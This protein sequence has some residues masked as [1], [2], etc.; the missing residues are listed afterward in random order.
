MKMKMKRKRR[1]Q[2]GDGKYSQEY[3]DEDV[4]KEE[5]MDHQEGG[6][7]LTKYVQGKVGQCQKSRRELNVL[8]PQETKK[9]EHC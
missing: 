9:K 2:N 8:V 3:Q 5:V 6:G 1:M 4:G 7:E